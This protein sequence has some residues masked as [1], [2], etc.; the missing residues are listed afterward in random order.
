ML[1]ISAFTFVG[2]SAIQNISY[3][4]DVFGEVKITINLSSQEEENETS[5]NEV[6]ESVY[7][8]A[9]KSSNL[10]SLTKNKLLEMNTF[11][12]LDNGYFEILSPPPK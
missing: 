11:L 1:L 8:T 3:F 12:K 9:L 10:F 2:L 5:S 4:S 6:K 7:K